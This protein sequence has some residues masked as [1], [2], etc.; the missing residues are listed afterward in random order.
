M[1]K[2][3]SIANCP[4]ERQSKSES[5]GSEVHMLTLK[6]EKK[7]GGGSK[8][9]VAWQGWK[10]ELPP[11]WGQ[12]KLEGTYDAG[13]ALFADLH[14]PRLG[15]KWGT[16]GK[17]KSFDPKKAL[18]DEVGQLAADEAKDLAMPGKGWASSML[19]LDPEPPGRDVWVAR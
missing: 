9:F 2:L 16:L 8:P 11:R 12:T 18:R 19:Y 4:S 17:N 1:S 7:P 13:Y 3:S 15:I 10:L 6:S 14:R 5:W